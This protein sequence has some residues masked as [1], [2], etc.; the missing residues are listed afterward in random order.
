[1]PQSR[2]DRFSLR[3]ALG[4][5]TALHILIAPLFV[6]SSV[7]FVGA[8]QSAEPL[9][10]RSGEVTAVTMMTIEHR[11]RHSPARARSIRPAA[12]ERATSKQTRPIDRRS[13]SVDSP[14]Q[15]AAGARVQRGHP[16]A[17]E[18]SAVLSVV[19]DPIVTQPVEA[20]TLAPKSE[21]PP[22]APSAAPAPPSQPAVTIALASAQTASGRGYDSP[23]GGWGQYFE[24]PIVADDAPL[25]DLR[26]KYHF[27]ATIT[28]NVDESGHATKVTFP[29]A[30]PTDVRPEIEKRLTTLRYV[31]AECNG[32]RCPASL[33][34]VI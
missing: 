9:G 20:A 10:F 28:V 15:G 24:R 3:H 26:S 17:A 12:S 30:V 4:L 31:P 23:N 1:M 27:S 25:N 8:G 7:A 2:S 19:R 34:I 6:V 11:L 5:S 29:N 13:V 16:A 21:V 33:A 32:L 14:A 18:G 22:P